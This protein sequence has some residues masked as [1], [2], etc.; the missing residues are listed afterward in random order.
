MPPSACGVVFCSSLL[1]SSPASSS[2]KGAVSTLIA[3]FRFLGPA[4]FG[5]PRR[6]G[7]LQ[8]RCLR[9]YAVGR[10]RRICL[11]ARH[12]SMHRQAACRCLGADRVPSRYRASAWSSVGAGRP[13]PALGP[14][15]PLM[16]A[17]AS[18]D[19]RPLHPMSANAKRRGAAKGSVHCEAQIRERVRIAQACRHAFARI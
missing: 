17:I 9:H 2:P 14:I 16:R 6:T 13:K 3:L 5:E 19:V 1:L 15:L 4:L 10:A 8:S 12:P 7:V 18:A 11:R